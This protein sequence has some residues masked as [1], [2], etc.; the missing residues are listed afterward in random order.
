[1]REGGDEHAEDDLRAGIA[2][3]SAKQPGSQ[4]GRGEREGYNVIEKTTPAMIPR[5][6]LAPSAPSL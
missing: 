5:T 1:M 4:L 3:K 6:A 2:H